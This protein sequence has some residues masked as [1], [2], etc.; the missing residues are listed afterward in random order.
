MFVNIQDADSDVR[1]H[2]REAF[3]NY[4]LKFPEEAER[5][6]KQLPPQG[7][8]ELK[9]NKSFWKKQ[10]PLWLRVF[11]IILSNICI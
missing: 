4:Q 1:K 9:Q 6:R 7:L 11:E 5:L 3:L 2:A 8:A 10:Y